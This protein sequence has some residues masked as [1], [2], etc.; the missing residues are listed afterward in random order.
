M[1]AK[2]LNKIVSWHK[3]TTPLYGYKIQHLENK[4]KPHIFES[5]RNNSSMFTFPHDR[6]ATRQNRGNTPTACLADK[7]CLQAN[8]ATN[9]RLKSNPPRQSSHLNLLFSFRKTSMALNMASG[10]QGNQWNN[11]SR[12]CE[13]IKHFSVFHFIAI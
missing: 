1:R 6:K 2:R 13:G 5:M 3:K 10:V 4:K 9:Q 7:D 12:R 8:I 11:F